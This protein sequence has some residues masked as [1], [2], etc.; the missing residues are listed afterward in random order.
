[1]LAGQRYEVDRRGWR[2]DILK[3]WRADARTE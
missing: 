2:D 3:Q 1:V